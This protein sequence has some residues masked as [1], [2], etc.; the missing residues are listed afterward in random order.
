MDH[1]VLFLSL[2]RGPQPQII[3]LVVV[4]VL[5]TRVIIGRSTVQDLYMTIMIVILYYYYRR[6]DM[7]PKMYLRRS[8]DMSKAGL[9]DIYIKTVQLGC[10]DVAIRT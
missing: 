3:R 2:P 1:K 7:Y 8:D 6:T 10:Y 9:R 5:Y 4:D